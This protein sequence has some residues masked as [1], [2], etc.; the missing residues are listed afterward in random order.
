MKQLAL[1]LLFIIGSTSIVSARPVAI[2]PAVTSQSLSVSTIQKDGIWSKI[3]TT[4]RKYFKLLKDKGVLIALIAHI[5]ILGLMVAIVMNIGNQSELAAFYIRQ[6]AG[7]SLIGLLIGL[8]LGLAYFIF[9][10]IIPSMSVVI[11]VALLVVWYMA[12][13]GGILSYLALFILLIMS[14]L[15]AIKG[16]Q[17]ELP[18]VGESFQKWFSRNR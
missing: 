4:V 6:V 13:S 1:L 10:T 16:E 3:K 8:T 17:K 7:L 15:S 9:L 5:P 2:I 18:F 12:V 11:F 14:L